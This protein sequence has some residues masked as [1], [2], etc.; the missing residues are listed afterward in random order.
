MSGVIR[1]LTNAETMLP[2]ASPI[3]TAIAKSTTLPR[4]MKS[5]KPFIVLPFLPVH[6]GSANRLSGCFRDGQRIVGHA[7]IT[8]EPIPLNYTTLKGKG[9]SIDAVGDS[10]FLTKCVPPFRNVLVDNR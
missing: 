5:R 9:V 4:K 3:T 8:I 1:S 2:K 7:T 6:Q 10:F